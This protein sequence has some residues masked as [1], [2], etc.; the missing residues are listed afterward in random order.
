M[1]YQAAMPPE[2]ARISAEAMMAALDCVCTPTFLLRADGHIVYANIAGNELL[3]RNPT[4]RK[5]QPRLVGRRSNE[6]KL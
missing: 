1:E 6:A 2:I 3:R 4:L 5:V